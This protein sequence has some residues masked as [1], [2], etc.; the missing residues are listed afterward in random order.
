MLFYI[1][2]KNIEDDMKNVKSK[3]SIG[4]PRDIIIQSGKICDKKN[5]RLNV[6]KKWNNFKW[7]KW[8]RV[9]GLVVFRVV[10]LRDMHD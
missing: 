5:M 4:A 6:W 3:I 2:M 1:L 10:I 8:E 9:V 7:S